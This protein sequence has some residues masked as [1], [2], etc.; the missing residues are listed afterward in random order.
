MRINAMLLK[1]HVV[2]IKSLYF[3][4]ASKRLEQGEKYGGLYGKISVFKCS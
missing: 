2:P 4:A 3:E 1:K